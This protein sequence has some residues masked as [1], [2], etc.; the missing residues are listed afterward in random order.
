MWTV[1]ICFVIF[2]LWGKKGLPSISSIR[3][4][5]S[6]E[7]NLCLKS[8]SFT[9]SCTPSY[10]DFPC[11]RAGLLTWLQLRLAIIL[12]CFCKN[13]PIL[14]HKMPFF[15][16]VEAVVFLEASCY[17]EPEWQSKEYK[18]KTMTEGQSWKG[19]RNCFC[20]IALKMGN[21]LL[22]SLC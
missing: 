1:L 19:I 13:A 2:N 15:V 7:L 21:V 20:G 6:V 3:K 14:C 4:S 17:Q 9:I 10:A 16:W 18:I 11:R 22:V 5:C 8:S 12:Y